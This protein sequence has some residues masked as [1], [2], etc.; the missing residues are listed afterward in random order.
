MDMSMLKKIMIIGIVV[1]IFWAGIDIWPML[2]PS[3]IDGDMAM[4][5]GKITP[6]IAAILIGYFLFKKD[7]E[8][9]DNIPDEV[10]K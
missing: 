5:A 3:W 6:Y 7:K 9:T 10:Q 4:R 1:F 2:L 8:I